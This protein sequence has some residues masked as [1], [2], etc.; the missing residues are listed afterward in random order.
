MNDEEI[1]RRFN[2]TFSDKPVEQKTTP[3]VV[4]PYRATVNQN[5]VPTTMTVPTSTNNEIPSLNTNVNQNTS[6]VVQQ[7]SSINPQVV[8][9]NQ[10]PPDNKTNIMEVDKNN[11]TEQ[12]TQQPTNVNYNYIPSYESKKKKTISIKISP[13]L[14]PVIIIV[15]ILF[16]VIMII[17]TVYEYFTHLR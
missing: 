7:P 10:T 14:K 4:T 2:E 11:Y 12:Q 13:E 15:I 1:M 16:V 6:N 17:P 3:E 9:N 8:Q 5:V